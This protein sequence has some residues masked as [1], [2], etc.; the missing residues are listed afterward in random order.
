MLKISHKKLYA[1]INEYQLER[2]GERS[3]KEE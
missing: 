3:E 1:K 2:P